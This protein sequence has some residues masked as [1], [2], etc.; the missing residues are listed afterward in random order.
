MPEEK[1]RTAVYLMR[2]GERQEGQI[3]GLSERGKQYV[4]NFARLE[5]PRFGF[6]QIICTPTP[7]ARE[8]LSVFL[9]SAPEFVL[10]TSLP[11]DEKEEIYSNRPEWMAV[12]RPERPLEDIRTL[13]DLKAAEEE[14]V[15]KGALCEKGF[16]LSEGERVFRFIAEIEKNLKDE[17]VMLCLMHSP[18]PEAVILWL[19]KNKTN[20]AVGKIRT[21]DTL[22]TL[23]Y[24]DAYVIIFHEG[25]VHRV[26]HCKYEEKVREGLEREAA[27]LKFRSPSR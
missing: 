23:N 16:V 21:P 15:K 24:L 27:N 19:L 14:A 2:V 11:I 6:D 8:T 3:S 5:F 17:M 12:I 25:E 4:V 1:R 18:L 9:R 7:L 26:I 20:P 22:S 13:A 10:T